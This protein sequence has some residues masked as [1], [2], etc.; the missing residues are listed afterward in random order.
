MSADIAIVETA[1]QGWRD[2]LAARAKMPTLFWVALAVLIGLSIVEGLLG[3][4][5]GYVAG[6]IFGLAQA[7]AA[8]PLAIAVHRFVLLGEARDSY[9]FNP[10]D[11]RFQKFFLF[12]IALEILGA[13]PSIGGLLFLAFAPLLGSLVML[14]L[15]IVVAIVAVRCAILFPSI[16]LDSPGADWRNALADSKGHSWRI[17][18]VLLCTVLP[19]S[20]AAILVVTIFSWSLLSAAIVIALILPAILVFTVAATA[21]AASRLYAAYANQLGR[22]GAM[23]APRAA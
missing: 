23:A 15:S 9:D 3:G 4:Y 21:A 2:A 10:G 8:T 18:L 19:G 14:V 17:F 5:L 11:A 7:A 1:V 16:A 22:P 20:I 13:I 6:V 12:T